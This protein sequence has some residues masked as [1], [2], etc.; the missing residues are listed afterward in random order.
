M[1]EV[2]SYMKTEFALKT[3]KVKSFFN[4]GL[5][6]DARDTYSQMVYFLDSLFYSK[7]IQFNKY[8]TYKYS[9][10]ILV[11][12]RKTFSITLY[13]LPSNI[14]LVSFVGLI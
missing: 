3:K 1:G 7:Q 12:I 6:K 4:S 13:Q 8:F 2:K 5:W 10:G 11:Y 14:Y 9:T